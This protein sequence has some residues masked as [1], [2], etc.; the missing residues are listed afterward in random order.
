MKIGMMLPPYPWE[1][2]LEAAKRGD[3]LG[4][5]MLWTADHFLGS[6]HPDLWRELPPSKQRPDPDAFADPFCLCAA[7]GSATSLPLGVGVTD[8]IRRAA[9]DLARTALTVQHLCRGGFNLGLGAGEAENLIP[10]GYTFEKPVAALQSTLQLLRHLLDTGHMPE[11]KGHLGL[12]LASGAGKPRIWVAGQGERTLRLT[13]QYADGW[14]ASRTMTM[15]PE[16]YGRRRAIVM[17]NARASGRPEPEAGLGVF[18][19]L[20]DSRSRVREMFEDQ[21]VAKLVALIMR[22]EFFHRHGVEHPLGQNHRGAVDLI[23]HDYDPDELRRL[24]PGIPFEVVEGAIVAGNPD[25][26]AQ[27]IRR[28]AEHGCEHVMLINNTGLVGGVAEVQAQAPRFADL[29]NIVRRIEPAFQVGRSASAT[30]A[31]S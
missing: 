4:V 29:C 26:I 12:P 20:G 6:W 27:E 10:F 8:G 23:A 16:E 11:G 21:P 31:V 18:I 14:L 5:D 30:S 28:Y 19:V 2:T 24:A 9:P 13:G 22:P 15:G 3:D 17:T 7:L 25:E 1:R